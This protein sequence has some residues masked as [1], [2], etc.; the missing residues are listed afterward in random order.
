VVVMGVR[1]R[2]EYPEGI[3]AGLPQGGCEGAYSGRGRPSEVVATLVAYNHGLLL[4]G[5][6]TG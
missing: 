1:I 4:A 6:P 3:K 5:A 2:P